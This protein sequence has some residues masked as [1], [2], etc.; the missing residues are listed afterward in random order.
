M[1]SEFVSETVLTDS[2]SSSGFNSSSILSSTAGLEIS[3]Q[4]HCLFLRLTHCSGIKL[5]LLR[6]RPKLESNPSRNGAFCPTKRSLHWCETDKT[7]LS[8]TGIPLLGGAP[9]RTVQQQ[10]NRALTSHWHNSQWSWVRPKGKM[11]FF[12]LQCACTSAAFCW[13]DGGT[14]GGKVLNKWTQCKKQNGNKQQNL[15]FHRLIE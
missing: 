9:V 3:V 14:G 6:W 8:N 13:H 10:A 12:L 11:H 5:Y 15:N 2:L 1:T 4:L 7:T